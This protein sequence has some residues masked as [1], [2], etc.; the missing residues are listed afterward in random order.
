MKY[1]FSA[2]KILLQVLFPILKVVN[3]YRNRYAPQAFFLSAALWCLLTGLAGAQP[4]GTA[5]G[6]GNKVDPELLRAMETG[7]AEALI[8]LQGQADLSLAARLRGKQAKGAYVFAQLQAHARQAQVGILRFLGGRNIPHQPLFVINAVYV[9]ALNAADC[10]AVAARSDVAA[11]LANSLLQAPP[12]EREL[13]LGLRQ[14]IEWGITKI[15]APAVWAMGV[16]GQGV[17]IGGQDTGYD[18]K[19]PAVVH[20]Y[21][22]WLRDTVA[23]HNYN[24]HDAISALSPLNKQGTNPCG[25]RSAVP[26]DDNAHGTH[27]MGTMLGDDGVGNQIGVAPGAKWIGC[28]NMERGYGSPFTYLECFQWFLAP[29]DLSGSRPDPARA[30]DVINNSWYCATE[31]GCNPTNFILLE[32]A[33]NNLRAAGIFVAVSAG[34]GGPACQ[35]VSGPPAIFPSGFVVGASQAND[36]IAGFSSRGPVTYGNGVFIKPDVVAPGTAVRSAMPGG[37]F[38]ALNGTSMAAPHVAGTVALMI[39]ANPALRGEVGLLEEI[40]KKTAEPL[41]SALSC[42]GLPGDAIPNPVYGFGR[43]NALEAVRAAMQQVTSV[44][45]YLQ[46]QEIRVFPNP[47]QRQITLETIPLDLP[48]VFTLFDASG[49]PVLRHQL[50]P[51][52]GTLFMVNLPDLPPGFYFYR[53]RGASGKLIIN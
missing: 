11:V 50:Q 9:P 44:P 48:E 25:L 13:A 16:S 47:A 22:G 52:D 26:C 34:N 24:W 36:S 8:L 33:V 20:Q 53:F 35:T 23:D 5:L 18:W 40:L 51:A 7:P 42:S 3:L 4:M 32:Q 38:A 49:R 37:G 15:Q 31:E 17:V 12:L 27:T 46:G 14:G 6:K 45:E 1:S 21:K 39:S 41:R 30:P 28:R 43:I 19:H 2:N 10:A 29:F